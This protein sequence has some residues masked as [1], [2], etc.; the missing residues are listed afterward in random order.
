MNQQMTQTI[1]LDSCVV[2]DIMEKPQFARKLRQSLRGKSLNF[3]LC[4]V[5]L[6]EV[7]RKRGFL[8]NVV[9][10][11]I[12]AI[13][14]R[15][16]ITETVSSQQRDTAKKIM[17]SFQGCHNGDNFILSLCQAKNYILVTLDKML[18]QACRVTGV[19]G[20]HA[21]RAGGI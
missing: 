10:K 13:F 7:K 6:S 2:I 16:I 4:D 9:R 21:M 11:R 3:V 15:Q 1:V 20:F 18:L 12:C 19:A 14:N 5:V 8:E 17:Y